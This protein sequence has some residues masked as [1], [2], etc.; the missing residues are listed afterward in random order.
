MVCAKVIG[1]HTSVTIAGSNGH[2]E[3][4][5]FKPMMIATLL[6]SIR[7]LGD[8]ALSFTEKCIDGIK[9]CYLKF[10]YLNIVL[11]LKMCYH[12]PMNHV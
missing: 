5:V 3:L 12:R 9:V 4:N 6:H 8:S 11:I 7:I 2:F 1:N 10:T